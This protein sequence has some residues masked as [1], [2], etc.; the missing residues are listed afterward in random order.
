MN[1]TKEEWRAWAKELILGADASSISREM[2][3]HLASWGPIRE[4]SWILL[5]M[6]LK[7]EPDVTGLMDGLVN[8]SFATTRTPLKG[9]LTIHPADVPMERHRFGYMQPAADAEEIEPSMIDVVL[10]PGLAF[11][12]RGNRLGWGAGYYDQLLV[13]MEPETYT[14]GVV[15]QE[16][17]VLSLPHEAHD[18]PVSHLVTEDGV[19]AASKK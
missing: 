19:V 15:P 9:P 10:V 6:P 13:R 7:G 12:R 16:R 8:S 11:D 4:A 3:R 1:S 18:V 17:I 14:V 2:V 5:Y